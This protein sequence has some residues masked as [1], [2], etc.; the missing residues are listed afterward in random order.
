MIHICGFPRSGNMF[1][2]SSLASIYGSNAIDRP[3]HAVLK[4]KEVVDNN[5]NVVVPFRKPEDCIAS[6]A[7]YKE[8]IYPDYA[9]NLTYS[10]ND[11]ISFYLR[12]MT[13]CLLVKDKVVFLDFEKFTENINYVKTLILEKFSI[14]TDSDLT[15]LDIKEKMILD[16]LSIHLPTD[17]AP[18]LQ[19]YKT[20]VLENERYQELLE[21]HSQI[22][23]IES[24]Y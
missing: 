22:Q 24:T 12:Y 10:I 4:L 11:H 8:V 5:S 9:Y 13:E 2:Y 7:L 6:W 3:N 14:S 18:Q 20:Q 15:I 1:L 17:T 19:G 21:I 23:E 16:G